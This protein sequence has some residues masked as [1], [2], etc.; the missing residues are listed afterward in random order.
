[1][2]INRENAVSGIDSWDWNLKGNKSTYHGLGQY[3]K[4]R[5]LSSGELFFF[6]FGFYDHIIL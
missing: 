4:V 6:F 2:C 1:M 5:L 3:M